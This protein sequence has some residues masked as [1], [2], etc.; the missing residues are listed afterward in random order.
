[1]QKTIFYSIAL[2]ASVGLSG[3]YPY[4][5]SDDYQAQP[6]YSA[7]QQNNGCSGDGCLGPC[8]AGDPGCMYQG[9]FA[10]S[11]P[12]IMDYAPCG[13]GP[14]GGASMPQSVPCPMPQPCPGNQPC[15]TPYPCGTQMHSI[16]QFSSPCMINPCVPQQGQPQYPMQ[17]QPYGYTQPQQPPMNGYA[18]Q[19]QYTPPMPIQQQQYTPPPPIQQQYTAPAPQPQYQAPEP[20]QQY[21]APAVTITPPPAPTYTPPPAPIQPEPTY[22]PPD[23]TPPATD[24]SYADCPSGNCGQ[25]AYAGGRDST[26]TMDWAAQEGVTLRVLLQD[27]SERAGWRLIWNTDR[28]YTVEAGAI[29]KGKYVDVASA[30][31]RAFSR[32]TPA[33]QATFYKGNRVLVITALEGEN[34]E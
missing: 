1:M 32:A 9:T 8:M 23:N 18:Q 12:F 16:M 11:T 17:P 10:T 21:A 34:A 26:M 31:V 7:Q 29:F 33:P 5:Y 22:L 27:W 4:G 2:I 14:C 13:A 19:Q 28:E 3:C 30:L 15:A 6:R 25:V 20:Q 24:L